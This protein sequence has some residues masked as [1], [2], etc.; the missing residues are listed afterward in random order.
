MS[1]TASPERRDDVRALFSPETEADRSKD[2]R[3][4]PVAR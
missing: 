2:A 1:S 4:A 3:R